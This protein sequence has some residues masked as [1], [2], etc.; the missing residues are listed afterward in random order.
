MSRIDI[1]RA[2]TAPEIEAINSMEMAR[3][4]HSGTS[5]NLGVQNVTTEDVKLCLSSIFSDLK[6]IGDYR[7]STSGTVSLTCCRF[8]DLLERCSD[9]W[10]LY[11][12]LGFE[13]SVHLMVTFQNSVTKKDNRKIK[14]ACF[15]NCPIYSMKRSI[16]HEYIV[17]RI[18]AEECLEIFIENLNLVLSVPRIF[19][20]DN[21]ERS[22]YMKIPRSLVR[23]VFSLETDNKKSS[24]GKVSTY[25]FHCFNNV[26]VRCS[27][28]IEN[29]STVVLYCKG[30][31]F[32][33]Q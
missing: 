29:D 32:R 11:K 25:Q 3:I 8:Q 5:Y 7:D 21:S 23:K 31:S 10:G 17:Y 30:M 14:I 33:S 4:S 20:Y 24:S 27:L 22:D 13:N 18:G 26:V 9:I 15:E 6:W 2:T 1:Y 16:S 19:C 28:R 12:H